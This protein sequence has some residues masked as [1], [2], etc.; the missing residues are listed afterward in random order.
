[1]LPY[2]LTAPIV[3]KRCVLCD[4]SWRRLLLLVTCLLQRLENVQQWELGA[5]ALALQPL[6]AASCRHVLAFPPPHYQPLA[7][8]GCDQS[9]QQLG[10]DA[11]HVL[12]EGGEGVLLGCGW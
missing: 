11:V 4:K 10:C 8:V 2:L 6:A 9:R 3:L 12:W 7:W 1:M 5:A